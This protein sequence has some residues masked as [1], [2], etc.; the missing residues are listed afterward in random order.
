[1]AKRSVG[2]TAQKPKIPKAKIAKERGIIP[3]RRRV[4]SSSWMLFE[5]AKE[6]LQ[7]ELENVGRLF[8]PE[9]LGVTVVGFSRFSDKH[10][11]NG[12]A[13]NE[14]INAVPTFNQPLE[15][16]L[17]SLGIFGSGG[18]IKLGFHLESTSITTETNCYEQALLKRGYPLKQDKNVREGVQRPHVSVALLY[19]DQVGHFSDEL[20]LRRLNTL[21][22]LTGKKVNLA[23]TSPYNPDTIL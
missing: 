6:N 9:S 11:R 16:E 7:P 5:E 14:F 23:P 17:G 8:I 10:L 22:R 18:K 21:A 2:R 20:T 3:I 12:P 19:N 1:M 13:T 15:V 4:D